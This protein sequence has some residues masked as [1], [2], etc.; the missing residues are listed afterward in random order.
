MMI[1]LSI[2]T[3]QRTN[4]VDITSRIKK[5]VANSGINEGIVMVYVPHTT[6]GITINENADPSVTRDVQMQLEKIAPYNA[7]YHHM[8]GNADSHIKTSIV[9]SSETIFIEN[10][11]LVLGTWQGIFLCDFDGPRSRKVYL[12]ILGE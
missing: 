1:T 2:P 11:K 9:G 7:G 6:C 3:K 12:K 4:F 10:G 5:E 8:E